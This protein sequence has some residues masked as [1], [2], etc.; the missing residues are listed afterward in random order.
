MS[1]NLGLQETETNEDSDDGWDEDE[2]EEDGNRL[3]RLQTG[4]ADGKEVTTIG[5]NGQEDPCKEGARLQHMKA[6]TDKKESGTSHNKRTESA[7]ANTGGESGKQ[8]GATQS[9]ETEDGD[10]KGA[11]SHS[12]PSSSPLVDLTFVNNGM[13]ATNPASEKDEVQKVQAGG[14]EE[15][16]EKTS[17]VRTSN[18]E[19]AETPGRTRNG[20]KTLPTD[21]NDVAE[22]AHASS[23]SSVD[24]PAPPPPPPHTPTNTNT[25]K[26]VEEEGIFQSIRKSI[27]RTFWSTDGDEPETA[28]GSGL[29][30]AA[31]SRGA[32]S[33]GGQEK[34]ADGGGKGET[35]GAGGGRE[36]GEAEL[37]GFAVQRRRAEPV[38]P[39][40][41]C[42]FSRG[43]DEQRRISSVD[44]ELIISQVDVGMISHRQANST[45]TETVTWFD[46]EFL[47]C[48][49]SA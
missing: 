39:K 47:F 49:T 28:A 27:K 44:V 10:E 45:S 23:L 24:T 2:E 34:V 13:G 9:E 11:S 35:D 17:D 1:Q 33:E 22:Q 5:R 48:R 46:C 16:T 42:K 18:D 3:L 15:V 31:D 41:K 32:Q 37:D 26:R 14:Q 43:F 7:N 25:S 20:D 40:K 21:A 12:T 38:H 6:A 36:D 29:V 4:H 8:E 19:S 30:S